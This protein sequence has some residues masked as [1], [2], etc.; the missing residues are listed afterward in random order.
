MTVFGREMRDNSNVVPITAGRQTPRSFVS[1]RRIRSGIAITIG[2]GFPGNYPGDVPSL[3]R[4]ADFTLA[5]ANTNN[6]SAAD[7]EEYDAVRYLITKDDRVRVL[8]DGVPEPEDAELVFSTAEELQAG[9]AEWPV[10]RLVTIWN[11]LP[12]V[13]AITRFENRRVAAERIWRAI[14]RVRQQWGN[15]GAPRPREKAEPRHNKT[16]LI[17]G[18]L[19]QP[20]G[21]TL[22]SLMEATQWQAHS[23]RGFLSGKLSKERGL[24]VKSLRREGERVYALQAMPSDTGLR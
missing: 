9:V 7:L 19:Q 2:P 24:L 6:R 10:R 8:P 18:M 4:I 13:K 23:V 17:M 11:K 14:E 20:S 21:A 15:S 3:P 22:K 12:E 16:E 1:A 5:V